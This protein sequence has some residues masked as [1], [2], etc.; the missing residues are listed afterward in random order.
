MEL[1]ML[2]AGFSKVHYHGSF[3]MNPEHEKW[4]EKVGIWHASV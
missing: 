2:Q 1:L 4:N 3:I